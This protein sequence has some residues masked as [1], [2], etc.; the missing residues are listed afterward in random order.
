MFLLRLGISMR[1]VFEIVEW[2]E[3]AG[4]QHDIDL[5]T[6]DSGYI[7]NSYI[8]SIVTCKGAECTTALTALSY[9][10][11]FSVF[12]IIWVRKIVKTAKFKFNI[13][14]IFL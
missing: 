2:S 14:N 8:F 11:F 9:G 10:I 5:R 12:W 6:F 7:W 1:L 13:C 3:K 4:S